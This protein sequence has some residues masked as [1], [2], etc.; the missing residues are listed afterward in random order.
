MITAADQYEFVTGADIDSEHPHGDLDRI[1]VTGDPSNLSGYNGSI[2]GESL[3]TLEEWVMERTNSVS[4][5]VV[6]DTGVFVAK[7]PLQQFDKPTF[8]RD[9]TCAN[10]ANVHERFRG[11][12]YCYF[13]PKY[14]N[15]SGISNTPWITTE[16]KTTEEIA[17]HFGAKQIDFSNLKSGGVAGDSIAKSDVLNYFNQSWGSALIGNGG[18]LALPSTYQVSLV[19]LKDT[20]SEGVRYQDYTM[21]T[22]G[23]A[24]E[25]WSQYD[26]SYGGWGY[27]KCVY[28]S[29]S[30][31]EGCEISGAVEP[32]FEQT[33]LRLTAPHASNV[34][35]LHHYA[36]SSTNTY[37]TNQGHIYVL[38]SF[39]KSGNVFETTVVYG[40]QSAA[41]AAGVEMLTYAM[42][43]ATVG[44]IHVSLD[45][46]P[47]IFFDTHSDF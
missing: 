20:T 2:R 28:T 40:A 37:Q 19:N 18:G 38:K 5:F 3:A 17:E 33:L 14:H 36:I 29:G 35:G 32:F 1:E 8:S 34:V 30:S 6:M 21:A 42:S 10:F 44:S 46:R 12:Q 24:P 47:I 25:R 7:S 16:Q 26:L 13:W 23:T 9:L 31:Y 43:G 45:I 11:L 41:S 15:I 4:N 39:T 27:T 22:G